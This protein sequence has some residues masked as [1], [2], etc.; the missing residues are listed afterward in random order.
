MTQTSKKKVML[1]MS[2]GVDSSVAAYL[3]KEEGYDVV[4]VTMQV[5]DQTS[6]DDGCC[7]LSSV[8]DARRVANRLDIPFYV[9]NMKE[10]F[11][12]Y[13]IDYFV[14]EYESGRTPNPCIACNR[15]IKFGSLLD[16]AKSMDIDYVATGHYAIIEKKDSRYLLKKAIDDAKDQSYVLYNLTQNQ[17]SKTLLPLGKYKKTEIREIAKKLNFSVASKPDSQEICFVED[18]DHHRFIKEYTGKGIKKG[19]FVD[20]DGNVLGKHEGVT[21]YTIGQRRGL[22]IAL[23]KP[24][25]VL[26]IDVESNK[27]IVGDNEELLSDGFS[28]YDLNWISIDKLEKEMK[29]KAKIRY[30]ATEQDAT[31]VPL[32]DGRVRV[33]LDSKQR[34]VTPGQSVVFYSNEYVVGGGIIEK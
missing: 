28:V 24:M 5:W 29:V 26:D 14:K 34:A 8:E 22:G 9:F 17:L 15:Y 11:R 12:K 33:I 18:N 6:H 13:V 4:G 20:I 23:G 31:I 16:K 27:V 30:K 3:L 32:E 1:G 7:S 2:G 25:F 19:N 21:K 10:E